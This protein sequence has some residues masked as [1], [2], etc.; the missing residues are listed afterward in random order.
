MKNFKTG[1]ALITSVSLLLG[2]CGQEDNKDKV[3]TETSE[4]ATTESSSDVKEEKEVTTETPEKDSKES[5]DSV[6]KNSSDS[7]EGNRIDTKQLTD[8]KGKA[9]EVPKDIKSL[10]GTYAAYVKNEFSN[11]Q[12]RVEV[13]INDD[14]S[15]TLISVREHTEAYSNPNLYFDKNNQFKKAD[16]KYHVD[17]I[18]S[19]VIVNAYGSNVL[20]PLQTTFSPMNYINESGNLEANHLNGPIETSDVIKLK[21]DY[22]KIN[23]GKIN[24]SGTLISKSN[25]LQYADTLKQHLGEMEGVKSQADLMSK[26]THKYVSLNDFFQHIDSSDNTKYAA[27]N[28]D[29]LKKVYTEDNTQV[30]AKFGYKRVENYEKDVHVYDGEKVYRGDVKDDGAIIV[31]EVN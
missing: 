20:V 9:Y 19:G 27:L 4:K 8:D 29:E 25:E 12:K 18:E 14:G 30:K 1:L 7:Q 11:Q 10:T 26:S 24:Y 23:N 31:N 16:K 17:K 22:T 28:S 15:Y 6:S 5:S 21:A 3:K 13:Q 2:A